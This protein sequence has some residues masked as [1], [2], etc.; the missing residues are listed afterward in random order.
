VLGDERS[1]GTDTASDT[2]VSVFDADMDPTG[3]N[4]SKKLLKN[5]SFLILMHQKGDGTASLCI[6]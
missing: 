5:Y 2:P 3:T 1:I 4:A 6:I